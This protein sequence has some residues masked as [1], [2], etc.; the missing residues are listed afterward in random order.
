MS[1]P[2]DHSNAWQY[3]SRGPVE[4]A[5]LSGMRLVEG[6]E[7]LSIVPI[8]RRTAYVWVSAAALALLAVSLTITGFTVLASYG[9]LNFS[10][11]L[12]VL[13]ALFLFYY[14]PYIQ[15]T[16]H[17]KKFGVEPWLIFEKQSAAI[18]LPREDL[19]LTPDRVY[20]LQVVEGWQKDGG[21]VGKVAELAIRMIDGDE[22]VHKPLVLTSPY[23]GPLRQFVDRMLDISEVPVHFYAHHKPLSKY[24]KPRITFTDLRQSD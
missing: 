16:Q 2:F 5:S 21:G 23:E 12:F 24:I 19:L 20:C 9:L 7:T 11:A 15:V 4:V 17:Y 18:I 22:I 10:N 6:D 1:E 3:V 14:A 13:L 8:P